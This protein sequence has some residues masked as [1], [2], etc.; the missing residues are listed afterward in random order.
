MRL[1]LH[2]RGLAFGNAVTC[3]VAENPSPPNTCLRRTP[4]LSPL[5]KGGPEVKV[6]AF[7]RVDRFGAACGFL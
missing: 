6:E 5:R 7:K 3:S 1:C 4:F 2:V